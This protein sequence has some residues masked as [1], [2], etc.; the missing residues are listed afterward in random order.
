MPRY[1]RHVFVCINR[2]TPDH[3][4]GCC[5]EKGSEEI[6]IQLKMAIKER[7]LSQQVRVNKAGCLDACG[8]GATVV[9]YPEGVWYGGV[10]L[11]DVSEI[12][13]KHIIGG[14]VVERLVMK[15]YAG[16]PKRFPPLDAPDGGEPG[17]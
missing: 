9:V 3:P 10:T 8:F 7:N 14:E 11:A 2:R 13:H 6:Q 5:A 15:P 4:K 12:L 1:V 16:G 17:N